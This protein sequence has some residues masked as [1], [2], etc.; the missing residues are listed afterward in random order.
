MKKPINSTLSRRPALLFYSRMA[1][2]VILLLAF[3]LTVMGQV[4]GPGGNINVDVRIWMRSDSGH[5]CLT[6][7]PLTPPGPLPCPFPG[8]WNDLDGGTF[9]PATL[10]G[11]AG[12]IT[13]DTSM[14]N[15]RSALTFSDRGLKLNP[16]GNGRDDIT[17]MVVLKTTDTDGEI[18]SGFQTGDDRYWRLYI[19]AGELKWRVR[20]GG[21]TSTITAPLP[22]NNGI[23]V[24]IT[25]ERSDGGMEPIALYVNGETIQNI[26]NGPGNTLDDADSL[27]ICQTNN[28][29]NLLDADIAEIIYFND[30]ISFANQYR[31]E[32]GLG[33]RYGITLVNEYTDGVGTVIYSTTA[34]WDNGIIG[35]GHDNSSINTIQSISESVDEPD[36]VTLLYGGGYNGSF[37]ISRY[38]AYADAIAEPPA[39][40]YFM[41]GHDSGGVTFT[42]TFNGIC[43]SRLGRVYRMENTGVTGDTM[44]IKLSNNAITSMSLAGAYGLLIDDNPTFSNNPTPIAIIQRPSGHFDVEF[45]VPAGIGGVS[46]WSIVDLGAAANASSPYGLP[47]G[48][49]GCVPIDPNFVWLRADSGHTCALTPSASCKMFH[50]S[51]WRD[52]SI[53]QTNALA[54]TVPASDSMSYEPAQINF[55]GAFRTDNVAANEPCF[56]FLPP[57]AGAFE[58]EVTIVAVLKTDETVTNGNTYDQPAIYGADNNGGIGDMYLTINGGQVN[59]T[60]DPTGG[61]S[62]VLSS[63]VTTFN[64]DVPFMVVADRSNS[65]ADPMTL[66]I[67]GENVASATGVNGTLNQLSTFSPYIGLQRQSGVTGHLDADFGEFLIFNTVL[68]QNQRE[69]L[70]TYLGIKY[71]LT[72]DHNYLSYT[73]ATVYDTSG[74]SGNIIG[75]ARED[76]LGSNYHQKQSQSV[77]EPNALTLYLGAGYGGSGTY[78]VDNA[79]NADTLAIND[80]FIL[81]HD[82]GD[83]TFTGAYNAIPGGRMDRIYKL[84]ETNTAGD[85][86]TFRFQTNGGTFDTLGTAG[87]NFALIISPDINFE[88]AFD[89]VL[90]IQMTAANDYYVE[91]VVPT[92]DHFMSIID[93]DAPTPAG[94]P[95]GVN[96]QDL[97]LWLKADTGHTAVNTNGPNSGTWF[98]NSY[99]GNLGFFSAG[100]QTQTTIADLNY[101][102]SITT[103]AA[104]SVDFNRN[105]PDA[106]SVIVVMATDYTGTSS[107]TSQQGAIIGGF[108][109][110]SGDEYF[111]T[112]SG[113]DVIWAV[114]N[115]AVKDS[116]RSSGGP[117]NNGSAHILFGDRDF[118]NNPSGEVT[119]RVD[120]TELQSNTILNFTSLPTPA[121]LRLGQHPIGTGIFEGRYGEVM[122][123]D[124]VLTGLDKEKVETYLALKYGVTLGHNYRDPAGAV[125]YDTTGF[126]N[127]IFGLA[128][129][130]YNGALFDQTVAGSQ[131]DSTLTLVAGIG[132]TGTIP[133]S[134]DTNNA[135]SLTA[136]TYLI[137]GDDDGNDAFNRP[138]SGNPNQLLGRT[139]KVEAVGALNTQTLIFKANWLTSL[140]GGDQYSVV[141]SSDQTFDDQDN[142]VLLTQA[143]A[144]N[145]FWAEVDFVGTS[146]IS[147]MKNPVPGGVSGIEILKWLDGNHRVDT[148]ATTPGNIE[149]GPRAGLDFGFSQ[150]V[151]YIEGGANFN[152]HIKLGTD[153]ITTVQRD[154]SDFGMFVVF[155]TDQMPV[156][157]GYTNEPAIIGG[158]KDD[159][160][161]NFGVTLGPSGNLVWRVRE[162]AGADRIAISA[163]TGYNLDNFHIA[164]IDYQQT[165]NPQIGL[166]GSYVT[167]GGNLNVALNEPDSIGL[168]GFDQ[169]LPGS[170]LLDGDIAEF[171]EFNTPLTGL[172]RD[173]VTTYLAIKYGITLPHNYVQAGSGTVLYD[174]TAGYGFD[175]VGLGTDSLT[176]LDQRAS[177]P[178]LD[179]TGLGLIYGTG[180]LGYPVIS[181]DIPGGLPEDHFL[182]IGH[183]NGAVTQTGVFNGD[184]FTRMERIYE[185]QYTGSSAQTVSIVFNGGFGP[186]LDSL[187]TDSSLAMVI[188]SDLS[189]D[190]TGGDQIIPLGEWSTGV[191]VGA[192][193][194]APNTSVFISVAKV[195]EPLAPGG[196]GNDPV[197]VWLQAG[198]GYNDG[199]NGTDTWANLMDP[200][201]FMAEDAL[202]TG[203]I[204]LSAQQLNFNPY[205][206]AGSVTQDFVTQFAVDGGTYI[207]VIR[208]FSADSMGGLMGQGTAGN[209]AGLRSPSAVSSQIRKGTDTTDFAHGQAELWQNGGLPDTLHSVNR[210]SILAANHIDP[211][212]AM[213]GSAGRFYLGGFQSPTAQRFTSFDVAEVIVFEDSIKY[214]GRIRQVETYLAIKYGFTLER[215]FVNSYGV[216]LFDTLADAPY[217]NDVAGIARDDTTG[218][219]QRQSMSE[220]TS[221]IVAIGLDSIV[222]SNAANGGNFFQDQAWLLWGSNAD[223]LCWSNTNFEVSTAATDRNHY[224][225][226]LRQWKT[227]KIGQVDSIHLRV[228][229]TGFARRPGLGSFYLA[230]DDDGIYDSSSYLIPMSGGAGNN[231]EAFLAGSDFDTYPYFTIG[232]RMDSAEF[233]VQ[234]F[235]GGGLIQLY[236]SNIGN[237]FICG[238]IEL[239]DGTNT[240]EVYRDG[241][242]PNIPTTTSYV[243]V[244]DGPGNCLDTIQF[245]ANPAW[246]SNDTFE[247]RVFLNPTPQI[248]SDPTCGSG[249]VYTDATK[250]TI[251]DSI[252]LGVNGS[253]NFDYLDSVY[254]IGAGNIFPDSP[255][256]S[257]FG[258][259]YTVDTS[260]AVNSTPGLIGDSTLGHLLV[261]S[262]VVDTHIVCFDLLGYCPTNVPTCDTLEIRDITPTF[263]AYDTGRVCRNSIIDDTLISVPNTLGTFSAFPP[264]VNLDPI[265]GRFSPNLQ[266]P[267]TYTVTFT[268]TDTNCFS[269]Y[270]D[271]ITVDSVQMGNFYFPQGAYCPYN[272]DA[273]PTVAYLPT[274]PAGWFFD[275]PDPAVVVDSVTGWVDLGLTPE[276]STYTIQYIPPGGLTCADTF[277]TTITIAVLPNV[278]F[279]PGVGHC[280]A[281]LLDT[282]TGGVFM[283]PVVQTSGIG[284]FSSPTNHLF[285]NGFLLDSAAIGGP[286][287][288]TYT[289]D[290][291]VSN[292][293]VPVTCVDSLTQ[294][295]T[296]TGLPP[297]IIEYPNPISIPD[298]YAFCVG[299]ANPFPI[300]SGGPSGGTFI[301]IDSTD[302]VVDSL[303][304]EILLNMSN[305]GTGIHQINYAVNSPG[306]NDTVLVGYIVYESVAD[307]A[308]TLD[309]TFVCEGASFIN[310]T[311]L[312][313]NPL[314]IT[315]N[316]F[317]LDTNGF[318]PLP[319]FGGNNLPVANFLQP[320]GNYTIIN[321]QEENFG[322]AGHVCHDTA[323]AYLYVEYR[324][325]ALMDY[326]TE[327]CNNQG[328]PNPVNLGTGGGYF[329]DTSLTINVDSTTGQIIDLPDSAITGMYEIHYTTVGLCPD[330]ISDV[331]E[332][333]PGQ[334]SDLSYPKSEVCNNEGILS[335]DSTGIPISTLS[336]DFFY[337]DTLIPGLLDPLTGD[338]T[339]SVATSNVTLTIGR[340]VQSAGNC[341]DT[342][343]FEVT[344]NDLIDNISLDYGA[345]TF[346]ASGSIA[347]VLTGVVNIQD[348]EFRNIA[349]LAFA[350]DTIG[351]IDLGS[352]SPDRDYTIEYTRSVGCRE[353]VTD[354]IYVKSFDDGSFSY[355]FSSY[356]E[357][358]D[359]I[360]EILNPLNAVGVFSVSGGNVSDTLYWAD[361]SVGTID[362]QTT[363]AATYTVS[364]STSGFCPVVESQ[365][366][367]IAAQPS[368]SEATFIVTPPDA[369]VCGTEIPTFEIDTF[370]FVT[371]HV[372]GVLQPNPSNL[373]I[374]N[375]PVDG[376]LVS[377][378][379]ENS[380]GCSDS[381]S[382]RVQLKDLPDG[383]PTTWPSVMTGDL[384]LEIVMASRSDSTS[385]R[386]IA[387]PSSNLTLDSTF[388]ESST[389]NFLEQ[390]TLF[391]GVTLDGDFNPGTVTYYITPF[392]QGC[393]G[394]PDTLIINVNP[395]ENPIFIP[396]VMTPNGDNFNDTW[397]VQWSSDLNPA[398]YKIVLFNRSGGEVFRMSPIH[399]NFTGANLPDGVYWWVLYGPDNASQG[400][401]GLTIRRR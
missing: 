189:F 145:R 397:L 243:V 173:M 283:A 57:A 30:Y 346:C 269:S 199:G 49:S 178:A 259:F 287:P 236:G 328:P 117:L 203:G 378:F 314:A 131:G 372:D 350:N 85:S 89:L 311:S 93:L 171:I 349:G 176:Y 15:F 396:G 112:M 278:Q 75:I 226:I 255:P 158:V 181:S 250:Y 317:F 300:F 18:M 273:I 138:I 170:L 276:D 23:P 11:G 394:V 362:L 333:L 24:V 384:P 258:L 151:E 95:G 7:S 377:G 52:Q 329:S 292:F 169:S 309:T 32:S 98:D 180:H 306:C 29:T 27:G 108:A 268:P 144:T 216:T 116:A 248:A 332:I 137:V 234:D 307:P 133:V 364:F 373:F 390:T 45:A 90:P 388:G 183:D 109:N 168:G 122:V 263:F 310:V 331:I 12:S 200:L 232:A 351:E 308:F 21:S 266:P 202:F 277:D 217:F 141:I 335:I 22:Y 231:I 220:N 219:D 165:V 26:A 318:T 398:D 284:V 118:F 50:G 8:P 288:I 376:A 205:I 38:E 323:F 270:S 71:G 186:M 16:N 369:A 334:V 285:F 155:R 303:T 20:R 166:D 392:S 78:P 84:T 192:H 160:G 340:V 149:W 187:G 56:F 154:G 225:R 70:Q 143:G 204:D 2:V 386:W 119:L 198:I 286:F 140:T 190:F 126:S 102:G 60:V 48:I 338:L 342:A 367:T 1:S 325:V 106:V 359:S 299:E 47:G 194:F 40:D 389:I 385:F 65:G 174:P 356:C 327:I 161:D 223:G 218:L 163:A 36:G 113:G 363:N 103:L 77:T 105:A 82:G 395:N 28:G 147:I 354:D 101:N 222:V 33:F 401:G 352:T 177:V 64:D 291:V 261:H 188:S 368:I 233:I 247:I 290:S 313:T 114:G 241:A 172:D 319:F 366:I 370:G 221:S 344:I 316:F 382:I 251:L 184:P 274:S 99:S 130:D 83:S 264:M 312:A 235:C 339:L 209:F 321:V 123:F 297:A 146:F 125:I 87:G 97:A 239:N 304:G 326:P 358:S 380:D 150:D 129:E 197:S 336:N 305:P 80:F 66:F 25:A 213:A 127:R 74:Y 229:T 393:F 387:E 61:S 330:T 44:T 73:G 86:I 211:G 281:D 212:N 302:L 51:A 132:H 210:W 17:V 88:T 337:A 37:P 59:W 289:R 92:G 374:Y 115:N 343:Y 272:G 257:T 282:I 164:Y 41:M 162:Q 238:L 201:N 135:N 227:S 365:V 79:S 242:P 246:A 196:L 139:W 81:G 100:N 39:G 249:S 375:N 347:P 391:N 361:Q 67:N 267:G 295:L 43:N 244:G 206:E 348:G 208:A 230:L 214:Q 315:P 4:N 271:T 191:F 280:L 42:E 345:D 399:P 136:A 3:S 275:S 134:S 46:Y 260:G 341:S 148:F 254:C 152:N 320:G 5:G 121:T 195:P 253:S 357:K 185:A 9:D 265:D 34:P 252:T 240:Y 167:S 63:P 157:T 68:T 379:L 400:A 91:T 120:G 301:S 156:G 182:L 104:S 228:D 383:D 324:D 62:Q 371:W 96:G 124:T 19:E 279:S 94:N 14:I 215:S 142:T 245:L 360:I 153:R 111:M 193:T 76:T 13:W 58:N 54:F 107:T 110:G 72:L 31:I 159:A 53:T 175:I 298:H 355:P 296:I 179:S 10:G 256:A 237:D 128:N 224:I 35:V 6:G 294:L 207:S 69:R 55:N 353:K 262:G 293:P 381:V 322:G